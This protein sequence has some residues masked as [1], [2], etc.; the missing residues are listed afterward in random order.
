MARQSPEVSGAPGKIRTCDGPVQESG[1]THERRPQRTTSLVFVGSPDA[2][3]LTRSQRFIPRPVPRPRLARRVQHGPGL[4]GLRTGHEAGGRERRL[5]PC[6]GRAYRRLCAT[7][8]VPIRLRVGVIV[9]GCW[10]S[11]TAHDSGASVQFFGPDPVATSADSASR[12]PLTGFDGEIEL[13]PVR[14]LECPAYRR[15]IREQRT[16]RQR[17]ESRRR[18]LRKRRHTRC[19]KFARSA[20]FHQLVDVPWILIAMQTTAGDRGPARVTRD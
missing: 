1:E 12:R 14:Q 15:R 9:R 13:A 20:T 11:A 4:R 17:A 16:V 5:L 19:T 2:Y 10:R 3:A 8:P 6:D 7:L 18:S